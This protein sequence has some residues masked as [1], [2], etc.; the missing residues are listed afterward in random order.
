MTEKQCYQC[1]YFRLRH[2]DETGIY[3]ECTHFES[4]VEFDGAICDKFTTEKD[5]FNIW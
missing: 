4:D 3:Y 2:N 5:I 1:A